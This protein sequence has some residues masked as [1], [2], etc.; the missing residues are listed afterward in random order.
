LAVNYVDRV[1]EN[2]QVTVEILQLVGVTCLFVAAK[3]EEIYSPLVDEFV[4]V[5]DNTYTHEE[6]LQTE[7]IVLNALKF[8]LT[9]TTIKDFLP[10]FLQAA[11]VQDPRIE[12][13]CN[14]L[15]EMLLLFYPFQVEY[16]PSLLAASIVCLSKNS[17][18]L[19]FWSPTF[20]TY[21]GYSK[22]DLKDCI[23]KIYEEHKLVL[24]STKHKSV[25]EKYCK[26]Q[27]GC[28]AQQPLSLPLL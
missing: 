8:R 17:F 2:V 5:T 18:Q 21:T 27:Y 11:N 22:T 9:V 13:H 19:P 24:S 16:K 7:R 12:L 23:V 6:I 14:H 15:A 26:P 28:V 3:Y 10:R 1:L 4:E 25:R 20:E